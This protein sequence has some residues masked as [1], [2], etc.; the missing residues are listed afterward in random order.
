MLNNRGPMYQIILGPIFLFV[1]AF[2]SIG[3]A[4]NGKITGRVYEKASNQSLPGTNVIVESIWQ[5]GKTNELQT[6]LGAATDSEGYFNPNKE[7]YIVKHPLDSDYANFYNINY[8][9]LPGEFGSLEKWLAFREMLDSPPGWPTSE[10]KT[11]LK[12]APRLGVAFP[13]TVNSKLYFNYGHFYQRPNVHFLYNQTVSPGAA[14]IPTSDLEMAKTIAYEFGYEQSFLNEF[15]INVSFYYKDIKNEPL[16]RTYIDFFE[17]LYVSKYFPDAYRDIRGIELRLEK[18]VGRFLTLWGNYEYMLRSSGRS[19]LFN[20][21]ENQLKAELEMRNPNLSIPEPLPRAHANFNLHTPD[22]WGPN[23]AGIKP[24]G[25]LFANFNLAW[26]DGGRIIINPYEPE[27]KQKRIEI[28]DSLNVDL[29]VSK[30]IRY[31]GLDLELVLT[32]QNLLNTKRL[33]FRNMSTAQFDRY[34]ESLH[35]PFESEEQHGNDK[36]G[37][38]DKDHIDVGWFKAPLF[39]NPRRVLLGVKV[40]F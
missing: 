9:Y 17:E 18:N 25:G 5:F 40:K 36:M 16:Y 8:Q 29:R 14:I 15:L 26:K 20:D 2:S 21:Y 11:Q 4:A 38:W 12:I 7:A 28:V 3:Y 1:F 23:V 19:G 34:K 39:L 37:D 6:K 30:T 27:E 31:A 32:V 35:F 10:N 24:F 13:I 22:D 33:S